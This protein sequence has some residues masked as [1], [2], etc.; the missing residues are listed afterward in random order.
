[1][2]EDFKDKVC[3]LYDGFLTADHSSAESVKLTN[4]ALKANNHSWACMETVKSLIGSTDR[5]RKKKVVVW[6]GRLRFRTL[7]LLWCPYAVGF[8]TPTGVPG[9][10]NLPGLRWNVGAF[11]ALFKPK[12]HLLIGCWIQ[13][14]DVISGILKAVFLES[15]ICRGGYKIYQ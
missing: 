5:F 2:R 8:K 7:S 9:V 1:M 13:L 6:M 3:D 10:E 12:S 15:D 4:S 11:P 14:V